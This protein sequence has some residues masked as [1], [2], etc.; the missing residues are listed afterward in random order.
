MELD[1]YKEGGI[2]TYVLNP[3]PHRRRCSRSAESSPQC[4]VPMRA[5]RRVSAK[6]GTWF[7]TK[8]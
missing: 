8:M 2:L 7:D 3:C 5:N 4:G 1:Y 6:Q